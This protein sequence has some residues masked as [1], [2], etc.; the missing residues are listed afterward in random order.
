MIP[1]IHP[2]IV[3]CLHVVESDPILCLPPCPGLPPIASPAVSPALARPPA[4]RAM[5]TCLGW[6]S[7][8]CSSCPR[9]HAS[10]PSAGLTACWRPSRP[11]F[12]LLASCWRPRAAVGCS[13]AAVYIHGAACC[14]PGA[15]ERPIPTDAAAVG[16]GPT[17]T[18]P[19]LIP[20]C[21]SSL[22][23]S[24][25]STAPTPALLFLTIGCRCPPRRATLAI[26]L[27]LAT[28]LWTYS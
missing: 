25:F 7:L 17:C 18:A 3:E 2:G 20:L 24:R 1:G 16:F 4:C 5:W 15:N 10:W 22:T 8:A 14:Q 19:H 23:C 26:S 21:V 27:Q 13:A 28:F 12:P 6:Y 11:S 9:W